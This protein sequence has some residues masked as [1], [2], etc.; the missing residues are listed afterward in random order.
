MIMLIDGFTVLAQA[1]NFLVLIV[2]LRHFLYR[3]LLRAV[4][5][6]ERRIAAELAAARAAREQAQNE[7]A[8]LA[9]RQAQIEAERERVLAMTL[10]DAQAERRNVLEHARQDAE[11]MQAE[12]HLAMQTEFSRLRATLVQRTC[13]EVYSL[14][15]RLLADLAGEQLQTL[16][17]AKFVVRLQQ[18]GAPE[19]TLL[20]SQG[21]GERWAVRSTAPLDAAEQT[22]L[23]QAIRT[24]FPASGELVFETDPHLLCGL[25]LAAGGYRLS[26]NAQDYLAELEQRMALLPDAGNMPVAETAS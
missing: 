19:L 1:I 17:V 11:R 14:A 18:G 4:A 7:S 8:Q 26:W 16:M 22:A 3:P 13:E 2:L 20:G 21:H 15:R 5:G 25:E 10:A 6:R 9:Q 24:A 23:E 12:W